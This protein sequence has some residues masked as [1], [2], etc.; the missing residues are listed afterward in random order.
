MISFLFWLLACVQE[1][2]DVYYLELATVHHIH[3]ILNGETGLSNV[4]GNHNLANTR[5]WPLEG[6]ALIPRGHRGMKRDDPVLP[7]PI[8]G[9][10]GQSFLQGR[11]LS[12]ACSV[13]AAN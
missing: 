7:L 9:C 10:A 3:H 2:G 6:L 5:G 1:S 4:G 11:Y 8:F 12:Y 13:C